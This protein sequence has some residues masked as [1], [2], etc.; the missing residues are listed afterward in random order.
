MSNELAVILLVIGYLLSIIRKQF[1]T[2]K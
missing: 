2:K 1:S